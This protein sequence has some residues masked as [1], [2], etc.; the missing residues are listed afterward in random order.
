MYS[1]NNN[2]NTFSLDL[3]SRFTN[4]LSN[5]LL[6]TYSDLSDLRGSTSDPFPFIDILDGGMVATGALTP[7]MSV[8]YELFTWN[9]A[10]HNQVLTVKDDLVYYLG[11]HKIMAGLS[12]DYQLADNAYMRNGTGYYRYNSLNDFLNKAAPE[13]VA[14]TYG[15]DG[16]KNP[17]SRVRFHKLSAYAQDNG[18]PMK[19][20]SSL[21]VFAS[22]PYSSTIRTS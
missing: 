18:T 13:T 8:G 21:Q 10:V 12:Y 7:Y 14:L 20:S 15:Y 9:N 1:M 5:Q 22:K 4:D 2:A 19:N 3:H 11:A 6:V 16:D 17:A